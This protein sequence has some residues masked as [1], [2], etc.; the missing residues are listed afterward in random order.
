LTWL[1]AQCRSATPCPLSFKSTPSPE[2]ISNGRFS[3][4]LYS[5]LRQSTITHC[6]L[7]KSLNINKQIRPGVGEPAA[8]PKGALL[9]SQRPDAAARCRWL[10]DA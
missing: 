3:T 10:D 2:P 8:R 7:L 1:I 6:A 9:S 5:P 4:R